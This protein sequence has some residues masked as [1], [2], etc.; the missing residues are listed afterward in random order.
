MESVAEWAQLNFGGCDLGDKRREKRLVHTAQQIASNPSASLPSQIELWSDLKAAYR[1]FDREEV[2]LEAIASPH[3][4]LTR[5]CAKGR[6][7]VL[8][9]T[10]EIS[11]PRGGTAFTYS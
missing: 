6:C 8:G 1:L 3:W 9:D 5:Q 11:Y 7:L 4:E 2:T 10:T